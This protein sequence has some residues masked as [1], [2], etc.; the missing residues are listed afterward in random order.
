[1]LKYKKYRL[2]DWEKKYKSLVRRYYVL[3]G[4]YIL[5]LGAFVFLFIMTFDWKDVGIGE[6]VYEDVDIYSKVN[7]HYENLS[8]ED[9]IY[10]ERVF[11]QINPLYL[12]DQGEIIVVENISSYCDSCAGVNFGRNKIVIKFYKDE[13]YLKEVVSHELLHTY[14]RRTF[15]FDENGDDPQHQIIYDLGRQQVAFK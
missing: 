5:L 14:W 3:F 12:T 7:L 2:F 4:T 15:A 8:N 1:M 11:N 6:S 10:F 9:I 13:D